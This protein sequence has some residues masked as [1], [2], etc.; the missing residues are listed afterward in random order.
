MSR[1]KQNILKNSQLADIITEKV[2]NFAPQR[3]EIF[4]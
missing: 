4:F 1:I 3:I 2:V